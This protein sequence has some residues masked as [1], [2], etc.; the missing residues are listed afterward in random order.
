[1]HLILAILTFAVFIG[2]GFLIEFIKGRTLSKAILDAVSMDDENPSGNPAYVPPVAVLPGLTGAAPRVEGYA[3]P[4]ALYYHQ[5]HS[6]VAPQGADTAIVG[7]DDFA[8]KLIGSPTSIT[9]PKPGEIF[10]QGEKGWTISQSDKQV[11]M[12]FPVDGKVVAVNEAVLKNPTLIASE[13]YG[14][15]WLFI[16]KSRSLQ[17][18][19]RNLLSGS[20]ARRWMEESATAFRTM[21]SGK[22]GIVYQDGGLPEDGLADYISAKEWREI[23]GRLFM[24][25]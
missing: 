1:M 15:G 25:E 18:N 2:V 19:L 10:R 9:V 14:R 6:W 11:K 20:V 7:I 3:L 13:P 4:E 23:T 22:L 16:I 5:G 12:V 17:R 24:I 8:G 21:F